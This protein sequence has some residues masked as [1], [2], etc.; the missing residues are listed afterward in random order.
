MSHDSTKA[1]IS[2]LLHE[3]QK[4]RKL[5]ASRL[6][7]PQ[8]D[9]V[10]R[11]LYAPQDTGQK[12]A[13]EKGGTQL[14]SHTVV[15]EA[16]LMLTKKGNTNVLVESSRKR[17]YPPPPPADQRPSGRPLFLE[18]KEESIIYRRYSRQNQRSTHACKFIGDI[19][20]TTTNVRRL[21]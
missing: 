8:S 20:D 7:N 13:P 17:T 6:H 10:F 14:T 1:S 3:A 21:Q 2:M 18:R 5:S 9:G 16:T 4:N 15:L 19:Q 12:N 11:V